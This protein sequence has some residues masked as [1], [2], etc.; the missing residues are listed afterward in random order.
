MATNTV[1]A[2]TTSKK[3]VKYVPFVLG[4]PP[5]KAPVWGQ[6]TPSSILTPTTPVVTP[7]KYTGPPLTSGP[8]PGTELHLKS[9][10]DIQ[11]GRLKSWCGL[12]GAGFTDNKGPSYP[13]VV[14]L[15]TFN[16]VWTWWEEKGSVKGP[17]AKSYACSGTEPSD[18]GGRTLQVGASQQGNIL[19]TTKAPDYAPRMNLHIDVT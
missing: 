7:A 13:H 1:P 17:N 4:P 9:W 18:K 12:S 6:Q 3:K 16:A 8:I 14:S 11:V 19:A 5:P 2:P 15:E 10:I